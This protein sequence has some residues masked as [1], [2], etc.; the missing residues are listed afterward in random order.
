M[1]KVIDLS[2]DVLNKEFREA[3]PKYITQ[4]E[5]ANEEGTPII[6]DCLF[7]NNTFALIS[8]EWFWKKPTEDG[9]QKA[10]ERLHQLCKEMNISEDE[11]EYAEN[12][13]DISKTL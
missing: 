7:T 4:W 1:Y 13:F 2:A 6:G 5:K 12:L 9:K 3:Y 11:L 8:K 10:Y